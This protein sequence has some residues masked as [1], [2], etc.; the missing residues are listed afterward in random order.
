MKMIFAAGSKIAL[1]KGNKLEYIES[2]YLKSYRKNLQEIADR[3]AWKS[4]GTGANFRG[5]ADKYAPRNGEDEDRFAKI[6]GVALIDKG[7]KILYSISFQG[8][9][10]IFV[11]SLIEGEDPETH[12]LHGSKA[13]FCSLD[14]K[15]ATNQI[16]VAMEDETAE[17]N[18]AIMD[19]GKGH[20]HMIT[21][22]DSID[23][24]PVWGNLNNNCIYFDSKG[25]GRGEDGHIMGYS[26]R[27]IYCLNMESKEIEEI[28]VM[29][30]F[31]CFLPKEDKEGNL[32]F[33][34][35]PY[36][37]SEARN[38]SFKDF[39]LIPIKLLKAVFN[40]LEFFTMRYTGEAFKTKGPNPA[41]GKND[42]KQMFI[43][44]NLVNV[45][46][47]LKENQSSGEKYPG[48]AP[49]NWELMKLKRDGEIETVKKGVLDFDL[50]E[51]GDIVY[52]NGKHLIKRSS[53]GNEMMLK[54]IELATKIRSL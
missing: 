18:L 45:E 33:I 40:F 7:D 35:K 28:A 37:T 9:S 3:H 53:D 22:G 15:K 2:N 13:R 1:L 25:I 19:M 47:T 20:Y 21:E 38:A 27:E 5:D 29:K 8:Y 12:V 6:N 44:D 10:G 23:D 16:V 46:K 14:Y 49:R 50:T 24:N 43:Y 11:R 51:E 17:R 48:I 36:H 42:P 30:D 31:D 4:Q 34:K 41:K 26:P 39:V 32:Y 54:E 52:S